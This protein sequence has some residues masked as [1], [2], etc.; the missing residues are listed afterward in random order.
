MFSSSLH[1]PIGTLLIEADEDAVTGIRFIE[2]ENNDQ[3]NELS[4][5]A[6]IELLAYF[7]GKGSN[8]TFPM[9][10][11]GT[12]FQQGVWQEL[13]NIQPGLPISYTELAKRLQN[14][15]GIRAIAATNGKNKLLIAVPCHRVIGSKGDLVGYAGELWR[16]GWLL[17]HEAQMTGIGQTSL[18][19]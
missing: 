16:K 18:F 7:E 5:W 1:S 15:L 17:N 19:L 6:K 8:F 12:P 9:K 2:Q 13:K 4:E 14:P 3:P 11:E 10:Q